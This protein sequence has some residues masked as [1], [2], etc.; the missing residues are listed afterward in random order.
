MKTSFKLLGLLVAGA[1]TVSA[2]SFSF[3][4]T[5]AGDDQVQLFS[6]ILASTTTVT[7]ETLGYGGG[8]NSASTVIPPG[9]FDPRLTWYQADG[10]E[11]GS[12]NGVTASYLGACNDAYFQ[13]T[14]DAGSYFLVLTEDG[15]DPLGDLSDGFSE[16]GNG[17]F[18]AFGTCTMFCDSLSGTQLTGNWDVEILGVGS[19]GSG[20]AAPEPRTVLL[21][22]I[23]LSLLAVA[24]RKAAGRKVSA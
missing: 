14:L 6:L 17:N 2:S 21:T 3:T 11:I 7:F 12:D 9:G 20:S 18:T 4:G 5:F 16:E 19:A 22:G 13:G 23:G 15:N 24:G 10:T 8:T 1:F